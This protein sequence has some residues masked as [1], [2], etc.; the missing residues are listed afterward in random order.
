MP[1]RCDLRPSCCLYIYVSAIVLILLF[2]GI[3]NLPVKGR[4][5][6]NFLLIGFC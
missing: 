1:I 3:R 5:Y 2:V 6:L 4:C